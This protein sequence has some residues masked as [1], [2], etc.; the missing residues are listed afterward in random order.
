MPVL[1]LVLK[2]EWGPPQRVLLDG[3]R[4]AAT[5]RARVD[6]LATREPIPAAG[7]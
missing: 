4:R 1:V 3:T 6:R 7:T 5:E 2:G